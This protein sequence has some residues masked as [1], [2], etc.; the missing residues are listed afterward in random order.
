MKILLL[1][2]EY[3]IIYSI[4]GWIAETFFVFIT[5]KKLVDRGFLIGPYCP[6]YGVGAL[7]IILYLTQY[8]DNI[9]TFFI[10]AVVVCSI[11]EYFTSYIM[12]LLFK[13]RWWDYSN[14]KFNLNGRICGSNC[15]L[16]GLGGIIVIY[17]IQPILINF[18]NKIPNN[19][20]TLINTIIL[21]I[22]IIDFIFSI[23]VINHF[24]KT[25]TNNDLKRDS[26]QEF[27]KVVRET[28]NKNHKIFQQRLINAFPNIDFNKLTNLKEEIKEELEE[29][30]EEIKERIQK[31]D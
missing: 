5:T 27:A 28:I 30:A 21:I 16:F 29:L 15:L 3:F 2:F 24:K 4:I 17:I 14:H 22:F 10:L 6:I 19:I 25:L 26:T 11:L 9:L 7:I 18:L 13:T 20:L 31:D 12:E 1:Y 8:K 23:N